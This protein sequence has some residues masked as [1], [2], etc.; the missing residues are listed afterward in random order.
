MS[1]MILPE[2]MAQGFVRAELDHAASELVLFTIR[3]DGWLS[4][5]FSDEAGYSDHTIAS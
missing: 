2:E 3:P 1:R 4:A 5:N